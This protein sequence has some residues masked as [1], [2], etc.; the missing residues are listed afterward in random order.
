MTT[1]PL[2]LIV[3]LGFGLVL[4]ASAR[5]QLL[6][7]ASPWRREFSLVLSFASLTVAPAAAALYLSFRDWSWMYLVD[8]ARLPAGLGLAAVLLQTLLVPAGYLL[9]W[10]LLRLPARLGLTTQ[11]RRPGSNVDEPVPEP[12]RSARSPGLWLFCVL[13]ALTAG[14]LMALA[15]PGSRQRLLVLGRFDDF[16]HSPLLL[17][18][19]G[20]TKV[21]WALA[22]VNPF[23]VAALTVTA[24]SLWR[25]GR[26]L[27]QQAVSEA[28]KSDAQRSARQPAVR[29]ASA[30]ASGRTDVTLPTPRP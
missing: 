2:N 23:V 19:A 1:I 6:S 3:C 13:G 11:P 15:L 27:R 12:T 20:Q 16:Q 24:I 17:R 22:A 14:L 28:A 10:L 8:P 7:G 18:P 26:W 25:G 30:P 4:A 5:T 29:G 21:P 9:G